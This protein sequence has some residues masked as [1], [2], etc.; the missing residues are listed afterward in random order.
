[1][2]ELQ[3]LRPESI[4]EALELLDGYGKNLKILAG[5]TDLI[6]ALKDRLINCNYLMD[7]KNIQELQEIRYTEDSGLEIGAAVSLN[8]IINSEII[9][10]KYGILIQAAKTLANSLLRNRATLLGNICNASPGGDMLGPSI[11]L[12]GKLEI[13]SKTG[14]RIVPLKDFFIGV[15]RTVLKEN[16]LVSKIIF[17]PIKGIGKYRRKSRIKGHDLAQIGVSMFLKN[18]SGLNVS[19]TAAA[20]VPV[21]IEDFNNL[22][23][24]ELKD[25]IEIIV[26]KITTS[27]KPIS[28]QRAS[29]EFRIE[30]ARYLSNQILEELSLEG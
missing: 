17:S 30:M 26:E 20:P 27:I 21:V 5:G 28:D 15:K 13:L 8:E 1:M 12:E 11:V 2:Q 10:E 24:D 4:K 23:K 16:E 3:Y 25:N 7:I 9:N 14:G 22:R 18:D 29:K 6:I 19:I